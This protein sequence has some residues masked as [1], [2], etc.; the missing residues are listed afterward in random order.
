MHRSGTSAIAR[1]LNLL[2]CGLP[3]NLMPAMAGNNETGFWE[4]RDV[5]DFNDRLLRSADSTWDDWHP[6]PAG[7]F[8]SL[9]TA[10]HQEAAQALIDSAFGGQPFI[11]LKDP[12]ICR[13]LPFWLTALDRAGYQT[14]LVVPLRHPLEVASSLR[15][16]DGFSPRK[17]QI[18]W[19]RHVLDAERASR[20]LPRT[21]VN[22]TDLLDDWRGVM[23]RI[24]Q[25]LALGLPRWS[26]TAE[27]E[28]D[29]FLRD[30]LRHNQAP[31]RLD[32]HPEVAGW[33][34]RAYPLLLAMTER[35][36]GRQPQEALQQELDRIAEEFDHASRA[37]GSVLRGEEIARAH[38][39]TALQRIEQEHDTAQQQVHALTEHLH[40]SEHERGLQTEELLTLRQQLNAATAETAALAGRS[41]S[42]TQNLARTQ[43]RA[44]RLQDTLGSSRERLALLTRADSAWRATLGAAQAAQHQEAAARGQ[45]AASLRDAATGDANLRLALASSTT[46]QQ[47][48]AAE[49]QFALATLHRITE[50]RASLAYQ[51]TTLQGTATWRLLRVLLAVE[52]RLP[53]LTRILLTAPEVALVSLRL[54]LPAWLAHRRAARRL[55]ATGLFDARWYGT[56]YPQTAWPGQRPLDHWLKVGR[57]G[58]YHP[59]QLFDT[60]FYLAQQPELADSGGDPLEHYVTVG[61]AEGCDPHPL[62]LTRWY[63]NQHPPVAAAG[64]NPLRHFLSDGGTQGGSPHPLFDS[65]WYLARNPD[66]ATA[67][68]NPL[69]HFLDTGVLEGRDPHPLFNCRWYLTEHPDVAAAGENP[70]LHYLRAGHLEERRPHPLFDPRWYQA[71]SPDL[72]AAGAG[73]DPLSHFITTGAAAGLTPH[74]LFDT[75]WYLK[76]NPDVA[77]AGINP[78]VHYLETG[79]AEGRDPHPLFASAWYL[80]HH[81]H[82]ASGSPLTASDN[83]LLHFVLLGQAQGASPHPLI[84]GA[85]YLAQHPELDSLEP[86]IDPVIHY[87]VQGETEGRQPHPLF[88]PVYYRGERTA[89]AVPHPLRDYLANEATGDGPSSDKRDPHPLFDTGWY[90]AENPD[91]AAAGLQPLLHFLE[92]GAAQGRRPHPLFDSGWYLTQNPDLP[93]GINPLHHYLAQG[94][95]EGRDPNPLFDSSWYLARH[96]ELADTG[97]N[98]LLHYLAA[99]RVSANDP[100]P[101]FNTAWYLS[102]NPDVAAAGENPLAHYL[103][104]GAAEGRTPHALFQPD[105]YFGTDH[106]L[107][108]AV[109][110][111]TLT[112]LG[113]YLQ[114]G[115]ERSPHPLLDASWYLEQN[116]GL[117]ATAEPPLLHFVRIGAFTGCNPHPLFDVA[118]YLEQVPSLIDESVN[119]LEHFCACGAG[120]GRNPHRLFDTAWYLHQYPEL[121]TTADGKPDGIE[122]INPLEHYLRWGARAGSSPHSLFDGAWYLEQNPRLASAS[123]NPLVHFLRWGG[124]EGRAPH[125]LFDS[126]WYLEQNPDVEQAGENPLLHYLRIGASEGRNP[127]PLFQTA[128]YMATHKA[129]LDTGENPLVHY[130]RSGARAGLKP[131]P[132][133][134]SAW[135]LEHNPEVAAAGDNPLRHYLEWGGFNGCNPCAAFDN[136]WYL[137]EYPDVA[138]S[139]LNPLLHYLRVGVAEGRRPNPD[140]Q[141][142]TQVTEGHGRLYDRLL[143]TAEQ[144]GTHPDYVPDDG[145]AL[146][147]TTLPLRTI[148]FYLPQFHPIPENDAWW[149]QG[150]TEWTNVAKAVPQFDG[151]DQPRLPDAL[152]FYDLRLPDIQREQIRLARQHGIHGFCYHYYWFGGRRLLERPLEQLLADPSLD[153]PFCLCWA[154]ENWTRRWD[155]GDETVL[156]GQQHSPADDRAFFASLLP[157]LHDRRYIR[158]QGRPLLLVYRP[159]LLPDPAAT[160]AR[161]R[162]QA[163]AAGLGG[164]YLAAVRSFSDAV[165]PSACGFDA[166]VDFPPHQVEFVEMSARVDF[167][168]QH[169]RGRIYDYASA[170]RTAERR[171][172]L[173]SPDSSEAQPPNF[174]GVM[175]AWDNTA[176]R[177]AAATIFAQATPQ[178]Y[179][180]WLTAACQC[181]LRHSTPD[182]RLVFINAWNEWAEGTY[183]EPDRHYGYAWLQQ[184][185]EVLA[186]VAEVASIAP[187]SPDSAHHKTAPRLLYVGHDALRH[188]AQHLSLHLLRVFATQF[189]YRLNLWL[190]GDGDL[191]AD[192]RRYAEVEVFTAGEARIAQAAHALAAAGVDQAIVNTVVSGDVLPEL[193]AQGFNALSLIHEMPDFIRRRGL[194]PQAQLCATHAQTLVF[195]AERVREA[196]ASIV[197]LD[198]ERTRLL[199]QGIY[200]PLEASPE[201]RVHIRDQLGL[202]PDA[203]LVLNVG[204]GD[205]RKGLDLFLDCAQAT[206]AADP[207]FHFLWVGQL[208]TGLDQRLE[209][210]CQAD[211]LGTHLHHQS[212][213]EE[214]A[215][216]YTAADVFLLSSREDPFPSVVLEAL[217]CGL[218][219]VAF[220]GSGGHCELLS[221]PNGQ[222]V[223][224]LEDAQALSQAVLD[225]AATEQA[226]PDWAEARASAA[227]Q[228][229]DFIDYAWQL[230]HQLNPSLQAVS[231]LVPNYNYAQFIAARLGSLFAQGYPVFEIIVLDDASTDASVQ[232]IEHCA[233]AWNRNIRLIANSENSGS[234]FAQWARGARLARGELLWIAEADDSAAPGFLPRLAPLFAADPEL[235]FA[236]CDSAQ[237]DDS[238]Q[239]LGDSYADYC[240][241]H[242]DLDFHRDF[243]LEGQQFLREGLSVKNTVLNVSA[244][245]FRRAPLISAMQSLGW[246]ED[247][248]SPPDWHIAGDWR[249]YI[250][251]CRQPGH[252]H[253][254]AKALN[255][256]RRHQH[257]IVGRHALRQHAQEIERMHRLVRPDLGADQPVA[258]RQHAYRTEIEQRAA[259]A[260]AP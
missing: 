136:A 253:Y 93:T 231:V 143:S 260:E 250:E 47:A 106:E 156:I 2:G 32:S 91:V 132:W 142:P 198:H 228:R 99:G 130:L 222:L 23:G 146:D 209:Q 36:D 41:Q 124:Q 55:A 233:A 227:R 104:T 191:L 120:E 175:L 212:F 88:D 230:L 193:T 43:A 24:E 46:H 79:A 65:A 219:I 203:I 81:A 165:D 204:F 140:H 7:W 58:G 180:R 57:A 238:S 139:G 168:N 105:W 258:A 121:R 113:H 53:R 187:R 182:E 246:C 256:H 21:L 196:Y 63:L 171:Y 11:V 190:L 54:R 94:A 172:A 38:A 103:R 153:F 128:W 115:A 109:M 68:R 85:W 52:R 173:G 111:S 131:C 101:L 181:T 72:A 201:A 170:A 138:A 137:A 240:N 218:P 210:A 244:V 86:A 29:A 100:H 25:E 80:S 158:I 237:I 44:A 126:A 249:L 207:R 127:H 169:F 20:N 19:L 73:C 188:G 84:D 49:A 205:H 10:A 148:A 224:P 122:G 208:E 164:L 64:L 217:C 192:Y 160:A 221:P 16:R 202:P 243:V 229:F 141:L 216:Y 183:L 98:P 35:S 82:A 13:L 254:L 18:L 30:D 184:T 133:F 145:R 31:P 76:H 226:H 251:L 5:A 247:A 78:L 6:M 26:D 45:L 241:L 125:P 102:H 28:I 61:A 42:L 118:S 4:S 129:L 167:L 15:R 213:T 40:A 176:R 225:V 232:E 107:R 112:P 116:P 195:A 3:E 48:D 62:F 117:L 114:Q 50:G 162:E 194:E 215:P 257:S 159:Q 211:P 90:L 12:R 189:G 245:L 22:Y 134:D 17:G 144:R 34:R 197:T 179:G 149:G 39:E 27:I 14:R 255:Q 9:S 71:Q 1:V 87:I 123:V 89:D 70:L 110:A 178:A 239:A 152:G 242:S 37:F 200:Q 151:Q 206:V 157:A 248:S 147:P 234:V 155:G 235:T 59:N 33:V 174:P 95:T 74:P 259:A 150:F 67:G 220:A 186:S 163:Q 8:N 96:P 51:L 97:T 166:G 60:D 75:R 154:N 223:E 135:Y 92:W 77:A 214:V 119:P 83:P 185:R 177:G 161:W 108:E 66:V 56:Q 252:I 199:P 236:F 69:L